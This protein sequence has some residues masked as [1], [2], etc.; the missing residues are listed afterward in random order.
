M[1]QNQG[2]IKTLKENTVVPS[3]FLKEWKTLTY[4]GIPFKIIKGL[5]SATGYFRWTEGD[6]ANIDEVVYKIADKDFDKK[7][8]SILPKGDSYEYFMDLVHDY[9]DDN[10]VYKSPACKN[11]N[12][13]IA[14][15]IKE[16]EEY[17]LKHHK[18]K[19]YLWEWFWN[20]GQSL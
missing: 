15:F 4:D 19:K 18:N 2:V 7:V 6:S 1:R 20:E 13:R 5:L 10:F 8:R 12:K 9:V 17:G 3:K 16:T 14:K 11:V